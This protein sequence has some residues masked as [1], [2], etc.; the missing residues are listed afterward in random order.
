MSICIKEY[1][2]GEEVTPRAEKDG[3]SCE[4]EEY[5]QTGEYINKIDEI[6][7]VKYLIIYF[8]GAL[9]PLVV[10]N[11]CCSFIDFF[12][13]KI[14]QFLPLINLSWDLMRFHKKFGPDRFWRLSVTN[15]HPDKQC[16]AVFGTFVWSIGY[17]QRLIL[18]SIV[19]T[20]KWLIA[21]FT[22]H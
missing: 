2:S 20:F 14:F 15:R 18:I 17:L 9:Y 5:E 22:T 13:I 8:Q 6:I 12:S 1:C 19:G 7:Q 3:P 4:W 11:F 21:R 10:F 16:L